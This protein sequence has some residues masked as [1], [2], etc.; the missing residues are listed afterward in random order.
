MATLNA[1]KM[2]L[3]AHVLPPVKYNKAC[4]YFKND[5]AQLHLLVYVRLGGI[6]V[7]LYCADN[8]Q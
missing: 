3:S 5:V 6:Y 1:P 2:A 4:S 8:M 7:R